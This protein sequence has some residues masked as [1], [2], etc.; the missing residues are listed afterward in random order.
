MWVGLT[1]STEGLTEKTEVSQE[2]ESLPLDNLC[3]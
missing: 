2:E 3:I 1:Q